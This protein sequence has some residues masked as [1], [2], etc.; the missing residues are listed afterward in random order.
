MRT[1]QYFLGFGLSVR[2]A[3]TS[4]EKY[5]SSAQRDTKPDEFAAYNVYAEECKAVAKS[6]LNVQ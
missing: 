3:T 1:D 2:T 4:T 6:E 5:H